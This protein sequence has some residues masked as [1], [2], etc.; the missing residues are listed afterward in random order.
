MM[1]GYG[2][3]FNA[4]CPALVETELLTSLTEKLGQFTL[5]EQPTRQILDKHGVI[6]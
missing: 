5:L 6:K 3:R 1:A 4:I 2:I